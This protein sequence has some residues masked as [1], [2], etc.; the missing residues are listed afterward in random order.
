MAFFK[1]EKIKSFAIEER[2][3]SL[4]QSILGCKSCGLF[5]QCNSPRMKISGNGKK[6]IYILGEAPGFKEDMEGKQFIGEMGQFLRDTIYEIDD[7]I[8]IDED[9]YL[10]NACRCRPTKISEHGNTINREPKNREINNCRNYILNSIKQLQPKKIFLLGKTALISFLGN[11]LDNI[12]G[13][14]KWVE[15]KIPDQ[16]FKSWVFPIYHPSYVARDIDNVALQKIFKRQLKNALEWKKPLPDYSALEKHVVIITNLDD[17][18]TILR[19]IIALKKP[20]AFDY[21]TNALK[22]HKEGCKIF[23][24]SISCGLFES[25]VF[26]FFDNKKFLLLWKQILTDPNIGKI[27]YNFKFENNW[28]KVVLG[29]NVNGWVADPM[30]DTHLIDNRT[31]ITGLKFQSYVNY[32]VIGYDKEAKAYMNSEKG[33]YNFNKLEEMDQKKLLLYCGMDSLLTY[34]LWNDQQKII[35]E[36]SQNRKSARELFLETEKHFCL[37]ENHGW[38]VNQEYYEIQAKHL[39]RRIDRCLK[40]IQE[41]NEISKLWKEDKKFNLRSSDHLKK[42]LFE[43]LNYDTEKITAKGAKSTDKEVLTNIDSEFTNLILETKKLDKLLNTYIKGMIREIENGKIYPINSLNIARTFR[44]SCFSPNSQN[45]PKRDEEANRLIRK[46]I[47]PSLGN[48]LLCADYGAIEVKEGCCYHKDPVMLNY[49]FDN[50]TDMHRDVAMDLFL[51]SKEQMTDKI[52]YYAKN[53]FVFPV[54]YGSYFAQCAPNLWKCVLSETLADGITPLRHHLIDQGIIT[55]D[56]FE[57]HVANVEYEF[58]Y[59]KFM[60]YSQWK[61]E[62][63]EFYQKNLYIESLDGFRYAGLMKR[64]D[65]FNYMIQGSACHSLL[66]SL[67]K[68]I[69]QFKEEGIKSRIIGQIHDELIIDVVPSELEN[70]IKIARQIMC[71]EIK[72]YFKWIIVPLTVEMSI[73]EI[74]G[75]WY[76]RKKLK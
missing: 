6:S 13:I 21:E 46:G 44:T 11:K 75:N 7:S 19:S 9:C 5:T 2:K 25:F 68:I 37:V 70:I 57:A 23:C 67:N 45:I 10:D 49:L 12:G 69:D 33:S 41:S 47:K 38:N 15:F 76:E 4:A 17:T 62:I 3:K 31:G 35:N 50:T 59:K 48:L 71:E 28:T 18:L 52:R 32:G 1:K 14:S 30:V 24:V 65:V 55:Y 56:D 43:I 51:L 73:S 63:W 72:K 36:W 20:F 26:P 60:V 27:A 58:W 61:E 74:N 64:N 22:P 66:W 40:K 39:Q 8:D 16:E 34:L 42:L 53:A 29:Y 54:F